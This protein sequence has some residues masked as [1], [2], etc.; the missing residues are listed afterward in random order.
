MIF[1]ITANSYAVTEAGR[2][3]TVK[4]KVY[5]I[6][7]EQR[8]TAEP[9]MEVLLK[10]AV[11]TDKKSRTKLFFMDDS[12]LNLGELSRVEIEEYLY[13]PEKKRSKS[14]YRLID[15]SLKVVVGRSELEIHTPTAV[16]AARGTKF[17]IWLEGTGEALF[18]GIT[19]L[20]GE[21][22]VRNILEGIKGMVTIRRGQMSR[23]PSHKPPE[24]VKPGDPEVTSQFND[25]TMV[26]G[27]ID[28]DKSEL[29]DRPP[30]QTTEPIIIME[31]IEDID[32]PPLPQQ[33]PVEA[34]TPVT[35]EVNF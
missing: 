18:T 27:D 29:P 28:E 24:G 17:I 4:K 32:E 26:M 16:A 8:N 33:E 3:L 1:I 23:I 14:I 6:R 13:S 25:K 7:E 31:D 15:G 5:L 34:F 35:I 2:V 20:E 30:T 22:T 19:V 10:D 12:I 9:Q 11:E 21:V